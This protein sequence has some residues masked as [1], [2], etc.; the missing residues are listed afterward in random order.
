[1]K[2]ILFGASGMVGQGV[3]RECLL[4]PDVASV[5]L[6]GR[7]ATGL[8]DVKVREIAHKDIGDLTAIEG[9]VSGYD[10]CFFCLGV[11][12]VGMTEADYRRITY[13]LTIGAAAT[14]VRLNPSMTFIYVSGMGTDGTE[15]GGTMWA[16]VKG[17]TENAL[18]RMPFK[19]AYMFRPAGIQPMNGERPRAR[20]AQIV[21]GALGPFMP[22]L[23]RFWPKYMTTTERI[24]R[25]MLIAAKRGAPKRVLES[26]DINLLAGDSVD[27]QAGLKPGAS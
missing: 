16:R 26:S 9:E 8:R 6:I 13:D 7:S 24:G 23:L 18:L 12:S 17:A 5:L 11:S 4:D 19:G 3:L 25:A 1:V 15:R 21:I 22:L 2:V 10:A 27:Y 20:G 14:L